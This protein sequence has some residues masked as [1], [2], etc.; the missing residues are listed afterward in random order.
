ME[1][2]KLHSYNLLYTVAKTQQRGLFFTLYGQTE[3][4]HWN[5]ILYEDKSKVV[6]C[7]VPKTGCTQM[8][9]MIVL[10]Q[11]L[12]TMKQPNN[13]IVTKFEFKIF[14]W[15]LCIGKQNP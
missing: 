12:Y 1:T 7:Y 9:T 11:G 6:Y 10:L 5:H 15:C 8:K 2:W 14:V 4:V 3:S 13:T